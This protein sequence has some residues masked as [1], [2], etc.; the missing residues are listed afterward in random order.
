MGALSKENAMLLDI[1]YVPSSKEH[2]VDNLYII[3]RNLDT[4]KKE[5]EIIPSPK[6]EIYFEKP[7]FRNFQ[8]IKSYE[9]L[10]RV[11]KRVVEYKNILFEIH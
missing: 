1:Q 2:K 9:Y 5:L 6:M 7:E 8:H 11:D 10:D 3:W 4:G